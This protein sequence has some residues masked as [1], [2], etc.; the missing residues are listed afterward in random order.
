M[1]IG[2]S[3][4]KLE[5]DNQA[6]SPPQRGIQGANAPTASYSDP[7]WEFRPGHSGRRGRSNDA[8]DPDSIPACE[9]EET[10]TYRSVFV[11]AVKGKVQRLDGHSGWRCLRKMSLAGGRIRCGRLA[12]APLGATDLDPV[13]DAIADAAE[14]SRLAGGFQHG[15]T[16]DSQDRPQRSRLRHDTASSR[17]PRRGVTF[18]IRR[19]LPMDRAASRA[20]RTPVGTRRGN[21]RPTGPAPADLVRGEDSMPRPRRSV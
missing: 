19:N 17:K 11:G 16:G 6:K 8:A 2:K 4:N 1:A 10:V 13:R 3:V 9:S 15:S 14:A 12:G 20:S 7:C 21:A 18:R 5:D